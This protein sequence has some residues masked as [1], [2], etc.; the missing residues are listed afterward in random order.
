MKTETR[1]KANLINTKLLQKYNNNDKRNNTNSIGCDDYCTFNTS[2]NNNKL[3][4]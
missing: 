3:G 4:V 1:K 2:G